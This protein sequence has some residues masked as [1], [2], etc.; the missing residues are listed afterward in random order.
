MN[1]ENLSCLITGKVRDRQGRHWRIGKYWKERKDYKLQNDGR[2]MKDKTDWVED[3]QRLGRIG[4][5]GE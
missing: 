1:K 2:T 3:M 5:D 4:K